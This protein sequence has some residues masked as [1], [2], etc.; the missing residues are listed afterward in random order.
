MIFNEHNTKLVG[1]V[2]NPID[3]YCLAIKIKI[4]KLKRKGNVVDR[5]NCI[6]RIHFVFPILIYLLY[7]LLLKIKHVR[8]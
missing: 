5:F 8:I 1:R 3:N 6:T 7:T 4:I 2:L